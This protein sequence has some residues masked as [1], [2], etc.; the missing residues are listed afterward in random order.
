MTNSFEPGN[1]R[2]ATAK[3]QQRNTAQTRM[4]SYCGQRM[5]LSEAA[6]RSGV[7]RR[8]ALK[9]LYKGWSLEKALSPLDYRSPRGARCV[10]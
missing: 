8:L 7:D 9:R 1:C 4:V 3:E 5:S 6:E 10:G 2:W